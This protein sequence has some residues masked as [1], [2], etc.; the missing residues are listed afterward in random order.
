MTNRL[1]VFLFPSFFFFRPSEDFI[2]LG[3]GSKVQNAGANRFDESLFSPELIR[4][5][6]SGLC[7][8]YLLI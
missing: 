2:K 6:E 4:E 7:F 5:R 8:K 3:S 1:R